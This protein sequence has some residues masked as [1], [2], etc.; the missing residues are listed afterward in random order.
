MFLIGLQYVS[1]KRWHPPMS[2]HDAKTQNIIIA[3]TAVKTSNLEQL[4]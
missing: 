3:L 4:R 2:L 1:P